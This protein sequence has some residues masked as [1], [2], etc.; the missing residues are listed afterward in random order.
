[1][2][3]LIQSL[4]VLKTLVVERRIN[5]VTYPKRWHDK[6]FLACA[7]IK[8]PESSLCCREIHSRV[9]ADHCSHIHLWQ[10]QQAQEYCLKI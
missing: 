5:R 10:T 2:K 3:N 9:T 6:L 8:C 7:V 1:M 4:K